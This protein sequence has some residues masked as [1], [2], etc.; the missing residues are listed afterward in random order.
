MQKIFTEE[1]SHIFVIEPEGSSEKTLKY[2]KCTYGRIFV[3]SQKNKFMIYAC[4][5]FPTFKLIELERYFSCEE[6]LLDSLPQLSNELL[7]IL[8]LALIP[9]RSPL[10]W[11]VTS[12]E[13][14]DDTPYEPG[15]SNSSPEKA[16]VFYGE[17]PF[18]V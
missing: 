15:T 6:S 8:S 1:R 12:S 13:V 9:W 14:F 16:A 17:R 11:L 4:S 18:V 2:A 7:E 5:I 3:P 10:Y